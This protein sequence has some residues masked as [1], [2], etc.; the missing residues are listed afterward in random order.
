MS[1]VSWRLYD[2]FLGR[3]EE[4]RPHMRCAMLSPRSREPVM[5]RGPHAADL[6]LFAA[7]QHP[8]LRTAVE[9][10]S[11]LLDRGYAE[12]SALKLVGDRHALRVRQRTAVLRS[13]CGD[14]QRHLR[15]SHRVPAGQLARGS[16]AIDGFNCIITVESALCG[17]VL[18]RGR[19]GALRD[20]ASVHGSYRHIDETREAVMLLGARVSEAASVSWYLDRP[21]SNSGRLR[22]LILDV[23]QSLGQTWTCE[24]VFDPDKV[25][26]ECSGV[27]ASSDAGILNACGA[28]VDL[29]SAVVAAMPDAW[30]VDLGSE[31]T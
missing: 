16:L 17:G 1:M 13:A 28:W 15:A 7:D 25:L 2:W 4:L 31:G 9:E 12:P 20:L 3:G 30:I 27:I 21:V 14:S 22:D 10:L 23:G 29:P 11:W 6:D 24:L 18:L 5:P 26:R 19:D 8:R